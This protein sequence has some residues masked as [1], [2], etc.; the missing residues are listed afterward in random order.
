MSIKNKFKR[1]FDLEEDEYVYEEVVEENGAE[2]EEGETMPAHSKKTSRMLSVCK[3]FTS[4]PRW[5]CLSR[6]YMPRRR[7]LQIS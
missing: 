5:C 1:F 2:M 7:I 3:V 4:S 6:E